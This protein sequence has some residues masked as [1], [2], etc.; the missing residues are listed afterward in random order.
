MC[1]TFLTLAEQ[2]PARF[3]ARC[4]HGTVHLGWD[5]A[6]WLLGEA[7]FLRLAAFAALPDG[8]P[9]PAPTD[10]DAPFLTVDA[11][12]R[13]CLWCGP[14]ALAFAPGDLDAFR[15]LLRSARPA[16][17]DALG[18]ADRARHAALN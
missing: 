8:A 5:G 9:A 16:L 15:R 14:R 4:E 3:V 18:R 6:V 17:A 13:D 10:D 11:R 2:S 12:G 7:G 1:Q